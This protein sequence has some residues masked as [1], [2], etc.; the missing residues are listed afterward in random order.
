ME[1]NNIGSRKIY[2]RRIQLLIKEIPCIEQVKKSLYLLYK[3]RLCLYCN[4][5]KK[6][7]NHIWMWRKKS[8]NRRIEA[9]DKLIGKINQYIEDPGKKDSNNI[10][11]IGYFL[12][13]KVRQRGIN[14]NRSH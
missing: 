4:N 10:N 9:K 5:E 3:N 2:R 14:N 11:R 7:F 12:E 8:R 6:D 13:Y 1:P